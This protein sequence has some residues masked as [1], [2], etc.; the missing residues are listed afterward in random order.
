[1]L[2]GAVTL[3]VIVPIV[4]VGAYRLRQNYKEHHYVTGTIR[5]GIN[6]GKQY[7]FTLAQV[8]ELNREANLQFKKVQQEEIARAKLRHPGLQ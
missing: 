3:L 2:W 6:R 8:D 1:L 5:Y 7:R 4:V